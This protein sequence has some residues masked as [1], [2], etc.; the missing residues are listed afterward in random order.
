MPRV[1][2]YYGGEK[3]SLANMID[4][5][6]KAKMGVKPDSQISHRRRE[7]KVV[8]EK[9]DGGNERTKE[10][11]SSADLNGFSFGAVEL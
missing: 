3:G 7:G 10:L 11:I 5:T 8:A 2:Q 9:G 1:W 4:V 6:V